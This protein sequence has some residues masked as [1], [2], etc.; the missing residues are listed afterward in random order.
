MPIPVPRSREF[1]TKWKISHI[2]ALA[3][4]GRATEELF[5]PAAE[6]TT[7]VLDKLY[8][9]S[10]GRKNQSSVRPAS[11]IVPFANGSDL[12]LSSPLYLGD[13]SFGALSGIPN[14]AIAKAADATSILAGT[15]EGGLQK[16]VADCSRITVQWASARFGVDIDTLSA[17][18]AVVIKI[19][20]GAKPGI[21]G[22]LPGVKVTIPISETRR[23]PVGRDAISPAPHHDIYSIEDLGQRILALKE[24]VKK[25]IFVKVG[26]T[27][28][29][30]YIASGI[31][32]MGASGIIID[33]AGAGTGAAPSVIKNNVGIPIE[34]AVASVDSIL[35]RENLRD[36]F[37]VIE[38]GRV[39]TPEDS[40]KLIALGANITSLGTAALLALGCL[41]VHKCHLGY[42]PA[43][44]T[45]KISEN[46]VKV[47][48]LNQSILWLMNLVNG[49]TQ[50]MKLLMELSGIS[51]IEDAVGLRDLLTHD[52][53]SSET[54][55][56]LNVDSL[57]TSNYETSHLNESKTGLPKLSTKLWPTNRLNMLREMA[58]TTGKSPAEAEISSMGS[59]SGP[60]IEEPARLSDW[61]VSDG[62]QVTRPSIDPYREDIEIF[63]R[64]R[65][66]GALRLAAPFFFTHLPENVPL[67]VKKVFARVAQ[68]LGLLF[69]VGQ[70]S[71]RVFSPFTERLI[72][73][74][75]DNENNGLVVTK[76]GS[77]QNNRL[78]WRIPASGIAL[79]DIEARLDPSLTSGFIIDEDD[80]RSDLPLEIAVSKLDETL[81]KHGIRYEVA[82]LAE[83]NM[84]RGADDIFKLLALG[85][86][87]AGLGRAGLLAVGFEEGDS[88]IVFDSKRSIVHLENFV[89][90]LEKEIKLLAGAAGVSSL[91]SSLVGNRELLRS[92]DL[93]EDV[94]KEL[95][96]KP[97]GG[98]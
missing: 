78:F 59:T 91:S 57:R 61:L 3:R 74:V 85:A 33:G 15:G 9:K 88:E 64:L 31:A 65:G 52:G 46:Q 97:S 38:A 81:K 11:T 22:H 30:P 50:E 13:M 21:G 71:T 45:N 7:R 56:I 90:A 37:T 80:P 95:G 54:L 84:I 75:V 62:A 29:I 92:I 51:E 34:L 72:S 67:V 87:S 28:Y 18:Q 43:V 48:S 94:R 40:L 19:G 60:S 1:W 63:S 70:F 36:K 77:T 66:D 96:I 4:T 2:R 53:L 23:I 49:W 69:D 82:L 5:V 8:L 44:L 20:Q 83:S 17:G 35:R 25:P 6:R 55:K 10:N 93:V 89:I 68:S 76:I 41:M 14:I 73:D 47:L 58:G 16:E 24:A 42:C 98:A 39:S 32:R 79:L 27:N 86:D 26:A 12:E